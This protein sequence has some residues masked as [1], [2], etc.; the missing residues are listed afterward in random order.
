M[1]PEIIIYTNK[2]RE[3]VQQP[4]IVN[5]RHRTKTNKIKKP[6][7]KINNQRKAKWQSIMDNPETRATMETQNEDKQNKKLN[8]K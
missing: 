1:S 7:Q 8:K 4:S 5:T 2:L 6:Q 3:N